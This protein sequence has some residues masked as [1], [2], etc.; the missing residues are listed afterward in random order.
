MALMMPWALLAGLFAGVF[1]ED[2]APELVNDEPCD[3]AECGLEMLHLRA[4][5]V[6]QELG[7]ASTS[8]LH[9]KL[10]HQVLIYMA[11][12]RLIMISC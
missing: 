2:F 4:R 10:M 6:T 11:R 1:A 3:G 7:E 8:I 9:S 12:K 5:K